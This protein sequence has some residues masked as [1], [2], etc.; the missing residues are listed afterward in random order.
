MPNAVIQSFAKKSGKS[1]EEIEKIWDELKDQYNDNYEAIVGTLKKILKIK[2]NFRNWLQENTSFI[3]EL[4]EKYK[5]IFIIQT[6]IMKSNYNQLPELLK[7]AIE[8]KANLF[9][10]SYLEDAINLPEIRM[11]EKSIKVFK[12]NIIP[13]MKQIVIDNINNEKIVDNIMKSLNKYYNDGT[14]LYEYHKN[15]ENCHWAG[16]HFTFYPNGTIDPCPGHEYFKSDYQYKINYDKINDF[17]KLENL[18]KSKEKCYDYCKYCPQGMHHEISFMPI[19]FN[20]HNSK[21]E[22]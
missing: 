5:F 1:E 10:P 18:T 13:K 19:S 8:N 21:E 14:N 9:W 20:E 11:D 6:I 3:K 2:K 12:E 22:I 17:M 7:F 4:K 16:K 15:G